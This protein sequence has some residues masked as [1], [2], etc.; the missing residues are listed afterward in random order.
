MASSKPQTETQKLTLPKTKVTALAR[1]KT[2]GS[3]FSQLRKPAQ[4]PIVFP[5]PSWVLDDEEMKSTATQQ[6]SGLP[7]TID[8]SHIP[9]TQPLTPPEPVTFALTLK[10]LIESLP[11]EGPW[12]AKPSEGTSKDK[13][14]QAVPQPVP[15]GLDNN[16]VRLLASEDVMKGNH[17]TSTGQGEK[18]KSNIWN[19]LAGLKDERKVTGSSEVTVE[20]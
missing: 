16:L 18:S 1:L 20:E 7:A 14:K 4:S 15:P 9:P 19:I 3:S 10:S 8:S 5:P 13:G 6:H 11:M 2:L 17:V 12:T